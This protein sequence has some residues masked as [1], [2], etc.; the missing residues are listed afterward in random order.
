MNLPIANKQIIFVDSSVQDYQSLIQGADAN[1]KIVIL[2]DK[3]SGI[4]Q[5][6]HALAG[7][8]DIA[9]VHV[10]S[11][12]SSGT[13]NLG[14]DIFNKELLEKKLEHL[15][16]WG[17]ALSS[18]ADFLLYGCNVAAGAIGLAFIHRIAEITRAN[19]A[20]SS[21]KIGNIRLGGNWNL[22]VQ[23][24][25]IATWL[26][27]QP[28][29]LSAYSGVLATYTVLPGDVSNTGSGLNG[30]LLWAI[31]Q[32]NSTAANDI[33]NLASGSTYTLTALNNTTGGNNGLPVI[34]G[35]STGGTLTITGNG[36]TITRSGAA[37][38]F[39]IF[40]VNSSGN[41]TLDNLTVSNG[42]TSAGGSAGGLYLNSGAI[43][44]INNSTFSNNQG[45]SD[46]G[47]IFNGSG[48][49]TINNSTF[50][51]NSAQA[52]GAAI[53]M[54]GG[55]ANI[56]NSTFSA[57]TA[58][59]DGG[60]IITYSGGNTT[61]V[62]ST[63][64]NN[65][66][67]SDANNTG[68]GGGVL[69]V[70]G[71]AT[72]VRNTIIAG[73]TDSSPTTK[74]PDVAGTF[75]DGGGNLIGNNTGSTS[76]T[77][78]TKV[79]TS[80]SPL[81]ALL[82]ALANNGGP[83]QTHS[84][85]AGSPALDSG[86][87]A[88]ASS[89]TLDQ[90]GTGYSR[91]VN[92]TV[93]IG[94]YEEQTPDTTAPTAASFTPADN[95]TSVAVAANLV[96]TLSEAVQKGT[97]NIVIKKTD[98]TVVET[99]DVTSA[100][101]TVTGSSV[102]I[103]PTANLVEGTDYYVEIAAGAIK[104]LAG[105]NYAGTTGAATWNFSTVA[106]T[107]PPTAASFT[108]ADNATNIAVAADLVVTLSEAV[109]K[110]TGNIVIKK[111]SDNS[112]VETIDVTSAN[113]TVAGSSVTINP[114][115]N[116]V[117]GTDY[118][119]EIAAGAIKDLAGNNYAG[120]TGAA[121][122]NFS[123]VADTTPP[124]AASFTPADNAT[125][126]AVAADLVVTLS[127]AVQKGTGN[128]VIK[129][130]SDNSVVETIDITSANVTVTGSSVTINPTA[131]L[132][133]GTD[134]YVEIAAGAIKDLAG[135]NY[136]GT[137][138]AATWNFTTVADTTAPTAASFTPADNAT[139]IAVAAD[140]VVT[141]SEAVQ[142][143]IG[144]IVIKKV[145][146]NSV[147]ETIDVTS[148]NVTVTG[149]TVT[150]NPTLDLVNGTDYYVEIA[151]GAIKDLAGNNYAGTTGAATWNF[152]TAPAA[153]T[154]AP[155]LSSVAPADNATG[156]GVG[157][158]LVISLSEAVAKGTGN[159]V[160]K[161]VSDNS[162]VETID[163]TSA[164]VTVSGSTVTINP[165]ADLA[166]STEYYVEIASGA[167]KDSAGN[168]Y[169]GI[170]GPTSW[171]FTTLTASTLPIPPIPQL[172]QNGSANTN[173]QG[174]SFTAS[175]NGTISEIAVYTGGAFTGNLLIYNS[176][177]GSGAGG[178]KGTP[179]YQ[180]SISLPSGMGW[181][182]VK[183]DTPYSATSGQTYSV[184]FEGTG[185]FS[186][187]NTNP[188]GG[189]NY[190]FNYGNANASN[191]LAFFI[192]PPEIDLKGNGTSIANQDI[193]PTTIDGT[194]FADTPV[195]SPLVRTFSIE[196]LGSSN[197][198]LSGTPVVTI[199]GANAS[200]F[201]VKTLPAN[202]ISASQATP[203]EITFQP[204]AIGTRTARINISSNDLDE[205]T[206]T[207]TIQ[208]N[209]LDGTAPT[210]SSFTPADNATNIT[211]A[212]DLV[213]TLSEAVQKGI[214]NIVIKKVSDNSVVET[215]DVTSANVTVTG[216]TVTVNPTADLAPGTDYYV[217]I[218]A[219]AIKNLGG[220]NYAGTTGATAWNFST[221]AA[222]D[223]TAPTA[224]F[225]PADNATS[226][227][228]AADLV[229]TL[230]EAVQKG[231][232][233]IVIKKVSDN[234]VVETID[235]TSTNVTVSGSTV[236]VNPTAD[237]AQGTDY[238]VEIAAS[239]IKDLAGNNYAGT[240]GAT[241]WN[242]TTA[243]VVDTTAPTAT[244]TPADNATSVAV[245]ADLVVT[246]SEAVQ[247]GIGNIVIKKVSDNSV[248]ETIDVTSANVTVSGSTVTVNPTADL[249]PGTDYYVEIASGAIKDLAGNNYAGT[250]G[251]TAWNFTTA[252]A[253]DTTAPTATFT[254]A[255][256]AT[257]VAVAANL[258]VNLSEAVQKGTGNIVIKKVSD[259]SVVETINVTAANVTV[260]GSTVTVNPTADLAQGT[261]YYVEIA[262]GAIKDLAGNNYAGTTGA[263]V[264][265][266]TTAAAVDTT[267]PTVTLASNAG[268]TVKNPFN[269]TATFNENV[270]GF[271]A[272]DISL[273]N[274]TVSG[275]TG[276]GSNYNFT[277][278]PTG[279]GIVTV[280]VPASSATDAAGNNN[281]AATPLTRTFDSRIENWSELD[282][283][284][285]NN[286][287]SVP[288]VEK[289]VLEAL[290]PMVKPLTAEFKN[291]ELKLTH[292]GSIP[293]A[294]FG[295][296]PL[297]AKVATG[298]TIP[299]S[300]PSLT[301]SNLNT[302]APTYGLSGILNFA[303]AKNDGQRNFL[304]LINEQLKIK[305][306]EL[307][308]EVRTGVLPKVSLSAELST[309]NLTLLKVDPFSIEIAGAKLSAS[310]DTISLPNFGI[311]GSF[312]IKGYDPFQTTEPDL[313]FSGGLTLD[314]KSITGALQLTAKTPWKNPFGLPNSEI[315]NLALQ[316]GG[317]YVK[318]WV[319]NVGFVGDLKFGNF[320]IKSAF[321]VSSNDP[322]KFAVE[323]TANA[324]VN[325]LDLW[326]G[327]VRSYLI[328]QVG[329]EVDFVKTA[330]SFLKQTLNVNIV[331]VD[332]PDADTNFDP[333]L[334][335]VPLETEIAQTKLTQGL[336]ING[337][338]TAWG[339]EASL[340]LNA[341]PYAQ[342]NPSLEGFLKIDEIDLGFLKLTG[343][344]G[345]ND[346]TLDFAVKVSP[347][348]QYLKGD[349]KL[350]IFGHT[351]AKANVEFTST[352]A[353]IKDFDLNY[354][355]V[356][357][358]INDF[359]VDIAK[360]TASGAGSVKILGREVAG[361]K[362]K[363]D[364][365]G[366][367]VEGKL[368]LF[369]V[370]SIENALIDIKSPTDIKIGGTAKI[371]GRNLGSANISLQ[372]GKV[373]VKG[374]IGYDIP[375]VGNVG[376]NLEITSDGTPNGS[377]VK[378]GYQA[379][380][381]KGDYTVSLAP[382]RSMEDLFDQVIGGALGAVT[383]VVN[384]AINGV[385]NGFNSVTSGVLDTFNKVG[386]YLKNA[387]Y[388]F[389][390]DVGDFVGIGNPNSGNDGNNEIYGNDADNWIYG[391]RG[392]D[393]LVG[394]GGNDRIWGGHDG[395]LIWAGYGSDQ[396]YGESGDDELHGERGNDEL[397]GGDNTDVLYGD[398]DDDKLDGNSGNDRLSGGS[399][400]DTLY[401]GWDQDELYGEDGDDDLRGQ[402]GYDNLRGGN[403]K[404]TL[405]G[406]Q[407]EDRLY[408][409][410]GNDLLSGEDGKDELHGSDNEDTLNGGKDTDVLYGQQG[411][412]SLQ[413][414]DGDDVLYGEDN[415]KQGQTYY[416]G[417][418]ND[419][420]LNGESGKDYLFGGIGNDILNGGNDN[421]A[422][423]GGAG[424]D[425]FD[426]DS[427]DDYL[428][429]GQGNDSLD[430]DVG[431]DTLFGKTGNDLLDGY[432]GKDYLYGG[433]GDDRLY[434][435]EDDDNL[436]GEAGN[437]Y[438]ESGKG[439]DILD[440]GEGND[441][442][443]GKEDDDILSGGNGSNI[444]DGGD[445]T[446]T[447]D[448]RFSSGSVNANLISKKATFSGNVD[449]LIGI[450]N[451]IGSPQNDTL[452]GDDWGNGNILS[453]QAGNDFLD[454][455][456]ANDILNGAEGNDILLGGDDNDYLVPGTGNDTIDGGAGNDTL[457]L[458]GKKEDYQFAETS[459][460]WRIVAPN[461]DVKTVMGVEDF[462]Y[463]VN[464]EEAIK[465]LATN[466]IA[467]VK[468]VVEKVGEKG[469]A[470][471]RGWV[472]DGYI[473]SGKVFL[474]ANLN[475]MLDEEESFTITRAD[476]SF[477]LNVEVEKFDTNQNGEIDYTEGQFVLMGGM[478]I[479]GGVDAAT[480]LSMATPL[481]SIL[482][483]T[484]V[485]P[486]T[487]AI[488]ELVKQGVDPAT[489]QTAVKAA[490]GLPAEVD[491]GSYDPLEAIAKGDANGVSVFGSMILVQ[492]TIVQTAKFIEGVSETEVAQL[493]FS[494][495]GAIANQVKG[496]AAVDLGKTETIL[497]IL[498]AAITKA[499]ESDPKINPTQLAASAAAAAQI[500]ALGNQMVKDLVASGR[501]IKDIALDITKLQA[502]SVGQIAVGLPE[503]AAGTVTVEEFLAQNSKEAILA[504]IEKVKVNDPTVRPVVETIDG[505]S[506][507]VPEEPTSG[508]IGT[509]TDTETDTD[510]GTTPV[511]PTPIAP[512]PSETASETPTTS[513]TASETPTPSE[514][515][516]PTP[517][518]NNL[519]DDECICD[520]ITYPNLN[521]PNSVENTI[522]DASDIQIGT[523]QNDELL[524]S[525]AANIFE[526]KSGDDNLYGGADNDIINGNQGNDFIAGGKDEDTLYG[527]EGSDIVLGESGN[528]LI[529]GGKG[530]DF[531]HGREGIDIIYGNK[532]DDFI[533]GG[534]DNDTLYGGKGND[535]LLGSQGDDN[536]FGQL[537]SDTICGGEGNDLING[538]EGAD[539]L[540]GCAG[541]DTL[542]GGAD[543]DTLTGGKGNDLLD[544]G[545]GNDSL[546]GGSGNDIFALTTGEGFDIIAD[547][548][549]GQDLIGLSGGLSFGQ[550]EITQN[551]QGTIIKNL[552]TGEQ[553]GVMVG[554]SA[555]A[556]TSANFMLV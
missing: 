128:I 554:V 320:D 88:N 483:S 538:D 59:N 404:D 420:T 25:K 83:T 276:T 100:N 417:S 303:D 541:N 175:E 551:T 102:T 85:Q 298:V 194:A 136:A 209:G 321:L 406:G 433:E 367:K 429:G 456:K 332:G 308:A 70:G 361:A 403:G 310:A 467:E 29:A 550:L 200:D 161:K 258:V 474:D 365:S 534:K 301:L 220:N 27:F 169:A 238:Y 172:T 516:T 292:D 118:Y 120:T 378:V 240:T 273:T 268:A 337:K 31:N 528:D 512:T 19:V 86:I 524:G 68:N 37:P 228:V 338:L 244:F 294:N 546:I 441:S 282:A 350:E 207:F 549:L 510:T 341:N 269:V 345:P 166:P 234:S 214:G 427:G 454:G 488:A 432:A 201:T 309:Q 415:G 32:A 2:D 357:L 416:S 431:N 354:G 358:D 130:V 428:D 38:S 324:P 94:A 81:N 501:P 9:A 66:A 262:A 462:S 217:E 284:L 375:L 372:N 248:L 374:L 185:T 193:T 43:A 430:G 21:T 24:G 380:A 509:E 167:I 452:V 508:E 131:N 107:T 153:D 34:L 202:T 394:K 548:T 78:S 443:Y 206:Y 426:G 163:V 543:N 359:S 116:L 447:A 255:D 45:L 50:T 15:Q 92:S 210:A 124:T 479:I 5:I 263:T 536:L 65:T 36:A 48:Q 494:G 203:F 250:T 96:V 181:K 342:S 138:G 348:E 293:F 471:F 252:A 407:D 388:E 253:V 442:L 540:G 176:S 6:T 520:Q 329:K 142:K 385:V 261:G 398:E 227:A 140:L 199:T 39:R 464:L 290:V 144:N 525:D 115:A 117:E 299:L 459:T 8:S 444:L 108:P 539:I 475:G 14:T 523:A 18:K 26:P 477:D 376:A 90:R 445:G 155:T 448:Y 413:G 139:N 297:V 247:K 419:D 98:G 53:T 311:V 486:L 408:G 500:M 17:K 82:N 160:I 109:Q 259:N 211:V 165:T 150:V 287:I 517:T 256:N 197:L 402:E 323:L 312:L 245:A 545:M 334:K 392:N 123:T 544:G 170:T 213:V 223:T 190:I 533:D 46:G 125:N 173:H 472:S 481:T 492:N 33:I 503:L 453:G 482:E 434:S 77:T 222:V 52:S 277:V 463:P 473:S 307:K 423:D 40:N 381:L 377:K 502:V 275:F 399:G 322:T 254:P 387:G 460:G 336:G 360:K 351:V 489:A 232:G 72:T 3:R 286:K 369:G 184:I 302:S 422:L 396:V 326:A 103:N 126:I 325:L 149:S 218:A 271:I 215:I 76:F 137:T 101:V 373:T 162:V 315:R 177:N 487:T 304:D 57:N 478:D 71:S 412:D 187:S 54:S 491:L 135:N 178:N 295:A 44:T 278:T 411:K 270:T 518:T 221:A 529:F 11:H 89:L 212:A 514:T 414:G 145:S 499:S 532:D 363:A 382:L 515:A 230:S 355:V 246:L 553:L 198:T 74:N 233:N 505:N 484:T 389:L 507:L 495:I 405:Y 251:A 468:K 451:I 55:T 133:E 530:N 28:A 401:G 450:D 235:V 192:N 164:N 364:S 216:S 239:A 42:L 498:Q 313:T 390:D 519:S 333:L 129:K 174:Q 134:Y 425:K 146:D 305:E 67:D 156:V 110:G 79:G 371:F 344:D 151:A 30:G 291:N 159:I 437:D 224:T 339:K 41:L 141:L 455:Q 421:D 317:T 397:S 410:A 257:S 22:D 279:S 449:G 393:K 113:V 188:Y 527:D 465:N 119:V 51:A 436:K 152:T 106:D 537:G 542:F 521:R 91:I 60:A 283:Y 7:E 285:K 281:I 555:D 75:S 438:L 265:N 343:A 154:T 186:F 340:S 1:A 93:D 264:W 20:A 504:R 497:A 56:S 547:F 316:V 370:L 409:D 80:G 314:P 395:D 62:N 127:E 511:T 466:A 237:L 10:V 121:T 440:G 122:W 368:D 219:G 556:I 356:A 318:P 327:P 84:L 439:K 418:W 195:G 485:T 280:N 383:G 143:G 552:L 522:L 446:D 191:D 157:A 58:R 328:K 64:T 35:T 366:L 353:K 189:G 180:Q 183:L 87:N 458:T 47:A 171:N 384:D 535:I 97:G 496:G 99:I 95:A 335:L 296:L 319:D 182:T 205:S 435:H 73:N 352:S 229:V 112:V 349:G 379:G 225:T 513:E 346:K 289:K 241:A 391:H 506:L 231:T 274:A 331:S 306:V 260:S 249:A 531:L 424:D 63:I 266:F 267:A 300:K 147:V 168:N 111:V 16:Q 114:T 179:T 243:A 61:I 476:G 457:S 204:S 493:A 480:G 461:G 470:F 148:A 469:L 12:G 242:F 132:V 526:G 4:E 158:D 49:L 13:L 236:T 386:D 400:K 490:L 208:G 272:S 362:I 330:E 69:N 347:T 105:N 104:D 288:N 226:V 23:I 196:N